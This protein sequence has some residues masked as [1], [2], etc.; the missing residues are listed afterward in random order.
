MGYFCQ[1]LVSR[2]EETTIVSSR[3]LVVY[4]LHRVCE[5]R[6]RT[7]SPDHCRKDMKRFSIFIAIIVIIEITGVLI[8]FL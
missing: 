3:E 1:E 8:Q 6:G 4:V 2:E 7:P 5:S